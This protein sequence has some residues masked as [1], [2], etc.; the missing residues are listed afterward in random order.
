M[1]DPCVARVEELCAD[2]AHRDAV[3]IRRVYED[4][5]AVLVE[6]GIPVREPTT[7]CITFGFTLSELANVRDLNALVEQRWQYGVR[8]LR[9][10]AGE[11]ELTKQVDSQEGVS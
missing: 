3:F 1:I 5:P 8:I 10:R 11:R 6:I 2:L 9:K 4:G 7:M